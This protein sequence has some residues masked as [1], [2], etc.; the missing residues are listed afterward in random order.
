MMTKEYAFMQ[1]KRLQDKKS[2]DTLIE[3]GCTC[4]LCG[5]S[6]DPRVIKP[7]V[8]QQHHV[9]G[10]KNDP[11]TIPLC[12]RCH[13]LISNGQR[14]WPISWSESNNDGQLKI[15]F[16][17]RGNSD[18]LAQQSRMLRDAS[19]MLLEQTSTEEEQNSAEDQYQ[20]HSREV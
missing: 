8:I 3:T 11:S 2:F 1:K 15:A 20:Q 16:M 12:V 17:L 7:S 5:Y 4:L 6:A 18:L 14:A 19:D 10:K 9:A 13:N